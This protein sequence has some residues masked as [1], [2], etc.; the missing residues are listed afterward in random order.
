MAENYIEMELREIHL[1]QGPTSAQIIVL[2]EKE[3][4]RTFPIYIGLFEALALEGAARGERA[5]RPLTH[6]LILNVIDGL[7]AQ[8]GR[9]LIVKLE[10]STF[11]GALELHTGSGQP[12]RIDARPSDAIVLATK[13]RIP[14]FVEE[15]VLEEV[16]QLI[17]E[18]EEE[19]FSFDSEDDDSD[20]SFNED[21]G[22]EDPDFPDEER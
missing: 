4:Q 9:V 6:D 13:R 17:E 10:G 15:K 2:G 18:E 3:G 11:Y 19:D 5:E 1:D 22:P 12:V 16:G 21:E 14:I 7:D 20:I 8:L